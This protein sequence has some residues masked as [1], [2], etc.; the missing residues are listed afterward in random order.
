MVARWHSGS[1]RCLSHLWHPS[2]RKVSY[3]SQHALQV[4]ILLVLEEFHCYMCG[5]IYFP[6]HD[7]HHSAAVIEASR[8]SLKWLPV[9]WRLIKQEIKISTGWLFIALSLRRRLLSCAQRPPAGPQSETGLPGV[10]IRGPRLARVSSS[11]AFSLI[12]ALGVYRYHFQIFSGWF[13]NE[14]QMLSPAG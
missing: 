13:S 14:V 3:F 9:G 12:P 8:I 5:L 10:T 7:K 2:L 1:L 4:S 6:E 11:T